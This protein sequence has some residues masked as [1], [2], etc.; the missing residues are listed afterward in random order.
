MAST[1]KHTERE[2]HY[3]P[4]HNLCRVILGQKKEGKARWVEGED[5]QDVG[6]GRQNK[7]RVG[8]RRQ[9]TMEVMMGG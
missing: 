9:G 2:R 7:G 8:D 1:S 5:G 6:E 4:I 3:C